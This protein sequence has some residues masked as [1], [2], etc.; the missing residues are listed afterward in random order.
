MKR[1]N[2]IDRF[3]DIFDNIRPEE[4]KTDKDFKEFL[5]LLGIKFL[6]VEG[7]VGFEY[8]FYNKTTKTSLYVGSEYEANPDVFLD[9]TT[10]IELRRWMKEGYPED[11]L[12]NK[13]W[14]K[15]CR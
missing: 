4:I 10:L 13:N 9:Q 12:D 5:K 1:L 8:G 15:S 3:Y 2:E 14:K 7:D 6:E 11:G